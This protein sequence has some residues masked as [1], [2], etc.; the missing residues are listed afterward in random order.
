MLK[1]P[2]YHLVPK[3]PLENLEFR[4][5]CYEEG[6]RCRETANDLRVMCARDILFYFN[7]FVWTY[8]PRKIDSGHDPV[9]P[10]VTYEYQDEYILDLNEIIGRDD[11]QVAK[12]RD[13]GCSWMTLATI[14]YRWQFKSFESF[15]LASWKEDLVDKTGDM[16]SL[17]AKI[18]FIHNHLPHWILH[19]EDFTRQN[20]IF[21][22]HHP[23]RNPS[24]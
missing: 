15:L 1:T 8:D 9:L 18:D 4:R 17:F 23:H 22:N 14:D 5:Y 16:D 2:Y 3:D 11:I 21:I 7:T 19:P 10:F 20:L 24:R 12:S 13:M 6:Y